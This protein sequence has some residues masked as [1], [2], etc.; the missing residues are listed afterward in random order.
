VLNW[1]AEVAKWRLEL[2]LCSGGVAA[3]A[4]AGTI[5]ETGCRSS[6][7]RAAGARYLGTGLSSESQS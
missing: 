7:W 2:A 3:Q 5:L 1:T 4:V 6:F